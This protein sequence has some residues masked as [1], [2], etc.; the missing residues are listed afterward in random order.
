MAFS[1][2]GRS[3][4]S[5]G[6]DKTVR[7]WDLASG[8]R[9]GPLRRARHASIAWPSAPTATTW[10]RP[11]R[12][13]PSRCGTSP[14]AGSCAS[15]RG[16]RTG[17]LSVAFSPDG[18]FLASSGRDTMAPD[19]GHQSGAALHTLAGHSQMVSSVAFSP[20]GQTIATASEDKT[21]K[22]WDTATGRERATFTGHT[23]WVTRVAFFPD[24]RRLA[25]A[26][27]D[28]TVRL[29]DVSTAQQVGIFRGQTGTYI[30]SLAVSPNGQW[31]ASATM[32][33]QIKVWEATSGPQEYRLLPP[34]HHDRIQ[35]V[36]FAPDGRLASCGKD[37]TVRLWDATTGGLTHI[38][39]GHAQEVCAVA[40]SIDNT[41]LASADVDGT[42]KSGARRTGELIR[43]LKGHAPGR[44]VVFSPDGLLLAAVRK[45]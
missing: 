28:M 13:E 43:T 44:Q 4:V 42:V 15:S 10:P 11:A 6:E 8:R 45:D 40:F 34:G 23:A 37:R 26:S 27:D 32:A 7:L 17:V 25:S 35:A 19:L 39:T 31:I 3:L 30:R 18:R 24:G 33:G 5:A 41:L 36:A 12:M 29:W 2:D 20:D 14:V 16:I 1:P 21:I 38:L 9:N 22:L